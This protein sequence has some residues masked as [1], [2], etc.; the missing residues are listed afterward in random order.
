MYAPWSGAKILK[1]LRILLVLIL[2]G[3][4]YVH[5]EATTGKKVKP[6]FTAIFIFPSGDLR[7]VDISSIS[8]AK[9][10]FHRIENSKW[11]VFLKVTATIG[12]IF[13]N[14]S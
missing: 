10:I 3:E 4:I 6:C 2:I 9:I 5:A 11:S 8:L 12:D 14:S 7:G 13:Y 1:W